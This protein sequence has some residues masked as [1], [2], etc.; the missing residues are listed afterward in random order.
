MVK[1]FISHIADSISESQLGQLDNR[2]FVFPTKRAGF[3]FRQALLDR[4]S[5]TTFWLPHILSIEDFIVQSTGKVVSSE[6]E[7][8]FTLYGAYSKTYLPPP[9]GG[10]DREELPTFDKFYAWGQVLLNDFDEV[11]RHMVAADQLYRNLEQLQQLEDRY[12]DD[13]ETRLALARFNEMMGKEPTVLNANFRNQWSRVCKTYHLFKKELSANNLAY[14][15]MLYRWLAEKLEKGPA[16]LP[17]GHVVFAGFNALSRSE[18]QI[19]DH[20]LSQDIATVYWD[21]DRLYLENNQEEAGKFMRKYRKKWPPSEQVHWLV[22][23]MRK[24]P[25]KIRIIGGVHVV[26]Q[27]QA[28][29]QLLSDFSQPQQD[30]CG[31]VLADEGALF[32]L[33][34]ALPS[35]I[36]ALNVTM[37]YPVRQS[38]WYRLADAFMQYQLQLSKS[39]STVYSEINYLGGLLADPLMQRAVPSIKRMN[40]LLQEKRKWLPVSEFINH[41]SPEI[42]KLAFTPRDRVAELV[43]SLVNLLMTIYQKLRLDQQLDDLETEFAYY[44]LRHLMQL[45]ERLVQ[46]QHQLEPATL[47]RLITE[48][49]ETVKIPFS[50]EPGKGLQVM[51]LL[52]TRAVDFERVIVLSANE[53]KLPRGKRFNSYI[54]YAIR[55]AF[56]LPTFE[57]QDAIYA[58]HF[59]RVLQRAKDITILY[60]TEVDI[61]GSGEKSRYIWQLMQAFPKSLISE[62]IYQMPLIKS[63]ADTNLEI[64][65]SPEVLDKMQ[66]FVLSGEA[67]KSLSPTAI[68]HYLDCSLRFYF[69]YVVRIPE[70]ERISTELD[71]RDFGNI[72][73]RALEKL[74]KP[75]EEKQVTRD[76]IE[77]LLASTSIEQYVAESFEEHFTKSTAYTAEGK[78]LL[79]RQIIEKLLYKAIDKDRWRA[80]FKLVGT[81]LAMSSDLAL[82]K[83]TTVRL[84][85]TLDRVHQ[86]RETIHILD[87]KTG[88]TDFIRQGSFR[89]DIDGYINEH[90]EDPNLK[91]GFQSFFYGY[92]WSRSR[93]GQ[94]VKLGVYP[95]K[96]VN[97]DSKWLYDDNVIPVQAWTTFERLLSETIRE[98]FDQ[99]VP[100][101]QTE[102]ATRCRFCAY[103]EICQR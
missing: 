9:Q 8:L 3:Y 36:R 61:D 38:Q 69:R 88:K 67:V 19:M 100:F 56:H 53:G 103:K 7:L 21:A 35:N 64:E 54:P 84:A 49:F 4:F 101:T 58:Y 76:M 31:V 74:F 91:A 22:T 43:A 78:E 98:L 82:A 17:F 5:N 33:L 14:S 25:G 40:T 97:E 59:K 51:G 73:H 52:E 85:G 20:L 94:A 89:N 44:S 90:F 15:G 42:V 10:V 75:W 24:D 57:E 87:Y 65:K 50:G 1:S 71:A 72:V 92:L 48:A 60:N 26:G 18:T 81:E 28:V 46:F 79:Q 95:L 45:E 68:R 62:Q 29:G 55:K 2:A 32:P 30:S 23:D 16:S 11:D 102:D 41:Q 86:A 99:A 66:R 27:T 13:E 96:R 37:G 70:R 63:S 47:A 77:E 34:Y 39:G 6:I 12:R 80:P 93:D 83:D